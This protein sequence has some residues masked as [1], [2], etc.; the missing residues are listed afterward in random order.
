M[1]LQ[2]RTTQ[3][4]LQLGAGSGRN[5]R[6]S[7]HVRHQH[8]TKKLT[9]L[10]AGAGSR[11]HATRAFTSQ[12][13]TAH[14]QDE[15]RPPWLHTSW[16][17]TLSGTCPPL[18]SLSAP[19]TLHPPNT[20]RGIDSHHVYNGSVTN[21]GHLYDVQ[22]TM[23]QLWRQDAVQHLN[24]GPFFIGRLWQVQQMIHKCN[25]CIYKHQRCYRHDTLED[26]L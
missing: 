4:R 20:G 16:S 18:A 23:T 9:G 24:F 22:T 2:E 7:L 1:T 26:N 13:C 19:C 8:S 25:V 14:R 15:Q 6:P 5:L 10:W 12:P 17:G 11:P 3:E 21:T